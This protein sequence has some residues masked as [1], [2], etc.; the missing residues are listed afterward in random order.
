MCESVVKIEAQSTAEQE[1]IL[2]AFEEAVNQF[3][4]GQD[5]FRAWLAQIGTETTEPTSFTG[6][7]QDGQT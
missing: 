4:R 6:G 7:H 1:A 2:L 3:C 5:Q